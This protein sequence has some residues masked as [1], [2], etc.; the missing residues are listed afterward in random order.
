MW[1]PGDLSQSLPC[2]I[3]GTPRVPYQARHFYFGMLCMCEQGI[4]LCL[5][6]VRNLGMASNCDW[7]R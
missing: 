4:I 1:L 5:I 6:A 2:F 3:F 7:A